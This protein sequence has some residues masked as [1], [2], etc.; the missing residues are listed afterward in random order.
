M[1]SLKTL[2]RI[3]AWSP[4]P[5]VGERKMENYVTSE[6]YPNKFGILNPTREQVNLTAG[7]NRFAVYTAAFLLTGLT[8]FYL[9]FSNYI[10]KIVGN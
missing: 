1:S 2:D 5:V 8:T 3:L 4:I 9:L 6:V 10:H 7:A